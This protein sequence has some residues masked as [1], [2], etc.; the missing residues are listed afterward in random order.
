M[1]TRP[2]VVIGRLSPER[3]SALLVRARAA[4][5][6]YAEVGSTLR[7]RAVRGASGHGGSGP[8]AQLTVLAGSDERIRLTGPPFPRLSARPPGGADAPDFA[9]ERELGT[10]RDPFE[11]A[12]AAL[13]A[14]VPQRAV[15]SVLPDDAVAVLGAT[16]LVALRLGPVTV[17]A[18]DRIVAVVD[19]A[20]R[21]GFAYGTL[22]GHPERGEEGFEVVARPDGSVVARVTVSARPALPASSL[23]APVVQ[24]VSR[25]YAGRYLDALQ[26]AIL[27]GDELRRP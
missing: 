26:A 11:R 10:G 6:T 15:A 16:V 22:P 3:A 14:F 2:I 17:V 4:E 21:W 13:R 8:F 12:R 23:L 7:G 18:P 20:D 27:A 1:S 24:R 25:H 5:P 19:E 9:A